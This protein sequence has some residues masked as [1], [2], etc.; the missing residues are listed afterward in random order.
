MPPLAPRIGAM[1]ESLAL[2]SNA[3]TT[4]TGTGYTSGANWS[5]YATVA[6]EYLAPASGREA[7]EG[8]AVTAELGPTF[9]IRDRSDVVPKHRAIW[10]GVTLEIH[11]VIAQIHVGRRF[12]LLQT[13]YT[14]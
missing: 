9:R 13:G 7:W 4:S 11:A 3:E 8:S 2:Q 12:L 14:Q 10:N 1:R 6:A 5:T